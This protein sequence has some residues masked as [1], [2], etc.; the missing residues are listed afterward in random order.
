[1]QSTVRLLCFALA[2]ASTARAGAMTSVYFYSDS[3]LTDDGSHKGSFQFALDGP[4]LHVSLA[5]SPPIEGGNSSFSPLASCAPNRSCVLDLSTHLYGAESFW[6]LGSVMVNGDTYSIRNSQDYLLSISAAIVSSSSSV[7]PSCGPGKSY[8]NMCTWA[9][10]PTDFTLSG[11]VEVFQSIGHS[12]VASESFSASGQAT[13]LHTTLEWA[14][15]NGYEETV[16]IYG[17]PEPSSL[18]MLLTGLAIVCILGRR[19]RRSIQS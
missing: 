13:A 18:P 17:T 6:V 4:D 16:L 15:L 14:S 2:A 11:T 5:G 12:R 8:A 10:G 9:Y 3:L 1:M 7:L 19:C